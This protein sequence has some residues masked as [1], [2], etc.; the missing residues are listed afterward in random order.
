VDPFDC[1]HQ[2]DG[3]LAR[4]GQLAAIDADDPTLSAH[5]TPIGTPN[6]NRIDAS[7]DFASCRIRSP[8]LGHVKPRLKID[9]GTRKWRGIRRWLT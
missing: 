8:G 4:G 3:L 5:T 7:S 9:Y 6:A 2:F 1:T